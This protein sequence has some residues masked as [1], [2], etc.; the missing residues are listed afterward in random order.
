MK[1]AIFYRSI[2]TAVSDINVTSRYRE[3]ALK[4]AVDNEIESSKG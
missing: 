3:D 2:L 1:L 4:P